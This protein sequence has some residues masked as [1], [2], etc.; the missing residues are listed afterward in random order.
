MI[1]YLQTHENYEDIYDK[2]TVESCR[3]MATR[4]PEVR[5]ED[6][7]NEKLTP[8]QLKAM[9]QVKYDW[10]K[11][12]RELAVFSYAADRY[13][14]KDET[15]SDWM[16]RDRERDER[17]AEIEPPSHIRCRECLS[18]DLRLI[19]KDEYGTS[20]GSKHERLLFMYKCNRCDTN[21]AYFNNGEQLHV[22]P[23]RCPQCQQEKPDHVTKESKHKYTITYT[24]T[25]CGHIWEEVMDFTPQPEPPDPN[26]IEDRKLYCYSDKVREYAESM[27]RAGPLLKELDE[28]HFKQ[29]ELNRWKEELD[30]IERLTIA[31]VADK[32]K[33]VLTKQGYTEFQL[34]Q[35]DMGKQ[36]IVPFNVIE[37][38]ARNEDESRFNLYKLISKQLDNSNWRL[39]RTSL[40]YRMGYLTG[41]LK[42]YES[43]EDLRDL[44][45][46]KAKKQSGK[47]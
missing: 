44:L 27:R 10:L 7:K 13:M 22:E 14:H 40:T 9:K 1:T 29:I 43:D 17:L 46:K 25:S 6:F 39:V 4:E 24:C 19:S 37:G 18:T 45:E 8:K 32:L 35:P 34:G 20:R 2:W 41:K 15:I 11:V 12:A 38:K 26:Y 33:K 36:V 30:K 28:H 31:Q 16:Q 23:T 42:G 3:R 47:K 5:D 21:T